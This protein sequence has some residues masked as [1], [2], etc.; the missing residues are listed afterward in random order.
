MDPHQSIIEEYY[1]DEIVEHVITSEENKRFSEIDPNSRLSKMN[2]FDYAIAETNQPQLN[3]VTNHK[4]NTMVDILEEIAGIQ[5]PPTPEIETPISAS[6]DRQQ[7]LIPNTNERSAP[8]L[9]SAEKQIID[10]KNNDISNSLPNLD[11]L[12][13]S[14]PSSRSQSR[15]SSLQSANSRPHS[16]KSSIQSAT[17]VELLQ[18]ISRQPSYLR[19]SRSSNVVNEQPRMSNLQNQKRSS[20]GFQLEQTAIGINVQRPTFDREM[21][22]ME[23][24]DIPTKRVSVQRIRE[25]HHRNISPPMQQIQRQSFNPTQQPR[26]QSRISPPMQHTNMPGLIHPQA[27]EPNE[28][29]RQQPAPSHLKTSNLLVPKNH[30]KKRSSYYVGHLEDQEFVP[31]DSE[32]LPYR[33]ATN[34]KKRG[35]F[36]TRIHQSKESIHR[37]FFSLIEELEN[38]PGSSRARTVKCGVI[39]CCCFLLFIIL[40][41]IAVVVLNIVVAPATL[42]YVAPSGSDGVQAQLN[43]NVYS[44]DFLSTVKNTGQFALDVSYVNAVVTLSTN[45]ASGTTTPNSATPAT[46]NGPKPRI[47]AGFTKTLQSKSNAQ[48]QFTASVDLTSS[49]IALCANNAKTFGSLQVNFQSTTSFVFA[50]SSSGTF[51]LLCPQ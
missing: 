40:G 41:A 14:N 23:P 3:P 21:R 48:F 49:L 12:V 51:P 39:S 20:V 5:L 33:S 43:N 26:Q 11:D 18:P 36:Q 25:Q 15:K 27:V 42:T 37:R 9:Q 8:Q 28:Q 19:K 22:N 46:T 47:S 2:E 4:R 7:P 1:T 38:K 24:R 50:K 45:P 16:R 30:T 44:W 29:I 32:Y 13:R 6:F 10:P 31:D 35:S 34:E 17:K